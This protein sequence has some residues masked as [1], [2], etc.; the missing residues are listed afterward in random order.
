MAAAFYHWQRES[1]WSQRRTSLSSNNYEV[2]VR[3][4]LSDFPFSGWT[5]WAIEI[6]NAA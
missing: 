5:D 1:A 2:S 3:L 4:D 6:L